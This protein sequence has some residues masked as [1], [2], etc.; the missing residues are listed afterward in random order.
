MVG[1][2]SDETESSL[3]WT[4]NEFRK[5]SLCG[6]NIVALDL[7]AAGIKAAQRV[8]P[9]SHIMLDEWHLNINQMKNTAAF[10]NEHGNTD[11]LQRC[12]EGNNIFRRQT[13]AEGT[14]VASGA[15][16]MSNDL[17]CLRRSSTE[18]VF[19]QRREAL[20]SLYF[21]SLD[22]KSFPKWYI[23]LYHKMHRMVIQCYSRTE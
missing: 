13:S 11:M 2:L 3:F 21:S 19:L 6:P 5:M 22:P 18:A 9:N 14:T 16:C 8:W 15:S 20:E 1:L 4:M 10:F 23:L 12:T 7:H 17:Y